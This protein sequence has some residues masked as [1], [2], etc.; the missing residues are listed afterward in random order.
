M[1]SIISNYFCNHLILRN[2]RG[3]L[4]GLEIDCYI[5][6][7]RIGFEYNGEQHYKFTPAFHKSEKDFIKQQKRDELKRVIAKEKDI[8][9][10]TIKYDEVLSEDL[11]EKKLKGILELE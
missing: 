3:F 9:L 10:I 8:K 11:I 4:D 2:T 6:D 7:L 5:P 1:E